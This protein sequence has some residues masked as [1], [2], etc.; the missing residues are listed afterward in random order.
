M[1][2]VALHAL[3][4]LP[5][6][7]EDVGFTLTLTYRYENGNMEG[8]GLR[9]DG[10]CIELDTFGSV[11]TEGVGSDSYSN[12][13]ATIS[14]GGRD[15]NTDLVGL[16]DWANWFRQCAAEREVD[17]EDFTESSPNWF[18]ATDPEPYWERLD[19]DY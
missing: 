8:L 7:T 9:I 1:C 15:N 13:L 14:V 3:Q 17:F 16:E 19:S 12:Q 5:L 6:V 11:Y 10:D 2:G 18:D 4:R